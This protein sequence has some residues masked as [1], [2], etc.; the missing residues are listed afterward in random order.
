MPCQIEKARYLFPS[1]PPG[2]YNLTAVT[3]GFE[4]VERTGITVEVNAHVTANLK[5]KIAGAVQTVEVQAQS[6]TLQT[7]DA[8][9]G[10]VVNRTFIENLPLTDRYVLDP[11]YA[12]A[13]RYRGR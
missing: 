2:T 4:K 5:L 8:T 11:G 12:S 9:T 1:I 7:E 13:R 3:S 6:S 10:Q